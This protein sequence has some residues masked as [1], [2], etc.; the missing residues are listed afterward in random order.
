MAEFVDSLDAE[1]PEALRT[2][3]CDVAYVHAIH[4]ELE[5]M[6]KD[7]VD[8]EEGR[9]ASYQILNI[10]SLLQ[11]NL[12]RRARLYFAGRI[13]LAIPTI[14]ASCLPFIAPDPKGVADF[15]TICDAGRSYDH[16]DDE[17]NQQ[18]YAVVLCAGNALDM[19]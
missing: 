9:I 17:K 4:D 15:R 3:M 10:A 11:E 16:S 6:E 18:F 7:N 5:R 14:D 8:D 1:A 12:T 2:R 13:V 19:R